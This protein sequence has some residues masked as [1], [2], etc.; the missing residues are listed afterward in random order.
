METNQ[1]KPAARGIRF[2]SAFFLGLVPVIFLVIFTR[3]TS[4]K[5]NAAPVLAESIPGSPI[6]P[7]V[8]YPKFLTSSKT[9]TPTLAHTGGATLHYAIVI[10][11]TGAYTGSGV[12][13]LDPIPANTAYNNDAQASSGN[14]GFSN[15]AV[16]WS[17]EVGFDASV[18]ISFSVNVAAGYSGVILNSAAISHTTLAEPLVIT[19]E[20]VITDLPIFAIEKTSKPSRP[21][22][23]KPMTYE[24]TVTNKG[25]PSGILPITV[26][27]KVPAGTNLNK[28]GSGGYTNPAHD[29]VTWTRSINLNFGQTSAFTFS[30]NIQDVPSGTVI[31]NDN[32]SVDSLVTNPAAGEVYTTTVVDPIFFLDKV[33]YPDPPGSNRGVVFTLTLLNKGSLATNLVITDHVP[34]GI[35]NIGGAPYTN[36]EVSWT[37]PQLD[38]DEFAHFTFTGDIPDV[39][40][41]SILNE[42]YRVCSAEGVC[43]MGKP[44]ST[45]VEG[46]GFIASAFLDP[47][48][49][50]S[51]G[52]T[53][54]VTPT[55]VIYN[56]GPGNA[57]DATALIYFY[58][59][60]VG[61]NDLKD[62]PDLGTF[63]SLGDCGSICRGY[64]WVGDLAYGEAVTL[65]TF[66][67]QSTFDNAGGIYTATIIITDSLGITTTPPVTATA[68]GVITSFANLIPTKNAPPV[69]AS[70]QLV[71]YSIQVRDGAYSTDSPPQ[72]WVSDLVPI[73]TTLVNFSPGG[74]TGTLGERTVISW[75]MPNMNPG[76]V[77]T[78]WFSVLVDPGLVSG[79]QI[80]NRDY[81]AHW[82]EQ[83]VGGV[84]SNTGVPITSVVREVGLIDSFKTVTPTLALPGTG[85]VLTYTVHVVNSGPAVLNDVEV[86][87]LFP[88]EHSTYQ[89]DAIASTGQV[90]SD[91][92]SLYWT[93]DL[94]PY[95]SELITFSVLVDPNYEGAITNTAW[96]SHP[97][98]T[99]DV[100]VEAVAYVTDDPV[101]V[102]SKKADPVPVVAGNELLYTIRVSNLGQQ[103][104]DLVITDTIPVNTEYV[105]GSASGSGTLSGDEVRWEIP[106]LAPGAS[107]EFTFRVVVHGGAQV[108]NAW[109]HVSCAEGVSAWGKPLITPVT[110]TG[111][112]IYLPI[113]R[114]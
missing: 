51:G 39:A 74:V 29:V 34:A 9:V 1:V 79:T 11:N 100:E 71:T 77:F 78:S 82:F 89:R 80:V 2:V 63:T 68:T 53:G 65:T 86:I 42:D 61:L 87:D 37:L 94:A 54:P 28:I 48:A 40:G 57:I 104:T 3:Q 41:I 43:Q 36:G 12:T 50:K 106:V 18:S 6:P 38:T 85:N 97:S 4:I 112:L 5:V 105:Q 99:E 25:Q 83:E 23:N 67:G 62:I 66:E 98:V 21:G 49:K 32:Y 95:S 108:I 45:W 114:K 55:L 56:E 13:L 35:T 93:G 31:T 103:A 69:V 76:E 102:I 8:G 72:P 101:L 110:Y 17:G 64:R 7:P 70:G 113:Q 10:R 46:A 73:S 75:T 84:I 91:I 27:D 19:A 111:G 88:W 109:Y 14:V 44:L 81:A 58:R 59:I 15:G 96:I 90:I 24:L 60:S 52:G 16:T 26:V 47:I 92:I 33:V 20:S 22:P 107:A 30:V